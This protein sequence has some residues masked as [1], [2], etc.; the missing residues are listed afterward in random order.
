MGIHFQSPAHRV[1]RPHGRGG[2]FS[3]LAVAG[4]VRGVAMIALL[5]GFSTAHGAEEPGAG[6]SSSA[7]T[8]PAVSREL[9]SF[10]FQPLYASNHGSVYGIYEARH[11]DLVLVKGGFDSGFKTG[12]VCRVVEGESDLA[13]VMLVDVRNNCAAAL[14][15]QLDAGKV[16]EPG[17]SVRIKTVTF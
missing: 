14:I 6:F 16:I 15:L 12:M 2:A 17:H 13:E 10:L 11:A 5:A 4:V 3:R 1:P 8:G 9:P 7:A